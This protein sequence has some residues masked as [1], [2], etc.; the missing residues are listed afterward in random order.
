[1]CF[2]HDAVPPI[3]PIQGAAI[4]N[5]RLHLSAADGTRFVAF[6][7]LSEA[8]GRGSGVVVL[9]DVRGLFTFYEELAL[10]FAEL[11]YDAIAIDY[12]GRTADDPPRSADF[13]WTDDVMA[14][15]QEGIRQDV[16][17]AIA[18]LREKDSDRKIFT[19][20]FCFGGSNSWH[21]AA[22]GHGL[23]GAIGFYGHPVRD[24]MPGGA[25]PVVTRVDEMECPILGLM[26]G[27]DP[28]IPAEVVDEY[29]RT[30]DTAGIENEIITYPAAPHS[31]FDRGY[32]EF[33]DESADAWRRVLAFIAANE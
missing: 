13:D 12:F 3:S 24:G 29:R 25:P 7:A 9:P 17:A 5:E 10:R 15:T 33:A 18:R 4:T 6:E 11:G 8:A 1:M 30:L 27:D 32:E 20:G 31:F 23:S 14:T 22:N 2:A 21:Q 16:A 26:G 19:I 28:G